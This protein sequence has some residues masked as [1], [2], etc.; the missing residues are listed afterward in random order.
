[1]DDGGVPPP[2]PQQ[3]RQPRLPLAAMACRRWPALRLPLLLLGLLLLGS[4][5]ACRAPAAYQASPIADPGPGARQSHSAAGINGSGFI[6]GG[7]DAGGTRNDLWQHAV[8]RGWERRGGAAAGQRA[9]VYSN[10]GGA[11]FADAPT[12]AATDAAAATSWPGSR[13]GATL[14]SI[15]G[16]ELYL[17]GGYGLA[18]APA[19]GYLNDMWV[20]GSAGWTWWGG[21][22]VVDQASCRLRDGCSQLCPRAV[23]GEHELA[24]CSW[25]GGRRSAAFWHD[26]AVRR[27]GTAASVGNAGFESDDLP[28]SGF[29]YASPTGWGA[30]GTTVIVQNG[31]FRWGVARSGVGGAFT[32]LLSAVG[33]S[34]SITQRIAGLTPGRLYH[35]SFRAASGFADGEWLRVLVDGSVKWS[36]QPADNF[37]TEE[38]VF[39]APRA[40]AVD[41]SFAGVKVAGPALVLDAVFIDDIVLK[42]AHRDTGFVFGGVGCAETS[43]NAFNQLSDLWW[44]TDGGTFYFVAGSVAAN[45]VGHYL[46]PAELWP[47]SRSSAAAWY[48]PVRRRGMV[49]GGRGCDSERCASYSYLND[50]WSLT[51]V[52]M[53]GSD[54]PNATVIGTEFC[55]GSHVR[56]ADGVYGGEMP[57]PGA[58]ESPA[59]WG[60]AEGNAYIFGGQGF[61]EGAVELRALSD[62]WRWD[63]ADHHFTFM[64]GM[65]SGDGPSFGVG[66]ELWPGA[67][68]RAAAWYD[69]AA[70]I[71]YV[72]GGNGVATG[73]NERSLLGELWAFEPDLYHFCAS[74]PPASA[75]NLTL[76]ADSSL[77]LLSSAQRQCQIDTCET[78]YLAKGAGRIDCVVGSDGAAALVFSHTAQRFACVDCVKQAANVTSCAASSEYAPSYSCDRAFDGNF[79]RD[80]GEWSTAGEGGGW[81]SFQLDGTWRIDGLDLQQR[82]RE[83]DWTT[84]M[85]IEFSDGSVQTIHPIQSGDINSYVLEPVSATSARFTL[86]GVRTV[87]ANSGAT[88]IRLVGCPEYCMDAD[89]RSTP[90][91]PAHADTSECSLSILNDRCLLTSC[92]DGFVAIS[93]GTGFV[94]CAGSASRGRAVLAY[95]AG[96]LPLECVPAPIPVIASAQRSTFVTAGQVWA[97]EPIAGTIELRNSSGMPAIGIAT[98]T[99]FAVTS[100]V[101]ACKTVGGDLWDWY[102]DH[103]GIEMS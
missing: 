39:T 69:G 54:E 51:P 97:G 80:G 38:M 44:Y 82:W 56:N 84:E 60:D 102:A 30:N 58:R 94:M 5:P 12:A 41:L 24:S 37:R 67:R 85:T 62:L 50:L 17:F 87:E 91:L 35:V 34:A 6:F 33:S 98:E 47:G 100:S 64:D 16:A 53:P 45:E 31:I 28:S 32:A 26:R 48:D 73:E 21:S 96:P 14:F 11:A 20:Y 15:G 13:L 36:A 59:S 74:V 86:S 66:V 1:M 63:S 99:P 57:W 77:C 49:F 101:P 8:G 46:G 19:Q 61:A 71:A 2:Q 103:L 68:G 43:C 22:D 83:Q 65:R 93:N 89:I 3:P 75:T 4:P 42:R 25:P 52:Y 72:S 78:D 55:G 79:R 18:A 88:E 29:V 76:H 23:A 92:E 70:A 81:I 40:G 7:E 95:E 90:G 27:S 9:G 10:R